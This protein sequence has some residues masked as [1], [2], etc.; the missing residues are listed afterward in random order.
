M[1]EGVQKIQPTGVTVDIGD[2]RVD[3]LG[4]AEFLSVKDIGESP[5]HIHA[6]HEFQYIHSGVLHELIDEERMLDVSEKCVLFIPPN[7]LHRNSAGTCRRMAMAITLQRIDSNDEN[8]FSEFAYYCELMGR[9]REPMVFKDQQI[10]ECAE[11]LIELAD[12]KQNLHKKKLL[13]ARIFIRAAECM[14][15]LSQGAKKNCPVFRGGSADRQYY[16]IE[17]YINTRYA[18]KTSAD[19]IAELLNVSRRQADRI[20]KRIFGKTYTAL[21]QERRMSLAQKMLQKTDIACTQIAEKTGYGTYAGFYV[22]F[23]EYFGCA[24]EEMRQRSRRYY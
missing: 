2:L 22:A 21:I 20:V 3:F 14:D 24:P 18:Q 6:V 5:L 8:S 1:A 17:Q 16:L 23:R 7:V 4:N 13:L 15:Q 19:E 9:I 12:T 11:E 10:L